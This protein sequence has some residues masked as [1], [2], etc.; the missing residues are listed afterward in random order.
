M[1]STIVHYG[2]RNVG[3]VVLSV[4]DSDG[5]LLSA[6]NVT[7]TVTTT[8]HSNALVI[9][10]EAL[11]LDGRGNYVYVIRND[12]LQ[13]ADVTTGAVNVSQAEIISGLQDGDEVVLDATDGSPLK[14]GMQVHMANSN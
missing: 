3:E 7:V 1:P 5:T 10:R 8:Q 6:T 11:R 9:P 12:R 4:D 13:R 2:T 14:E